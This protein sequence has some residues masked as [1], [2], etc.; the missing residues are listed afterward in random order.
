MEDLLL[1][2][3]SFEVYSSSDGARILARNRMLMNYPD[4]K[5]SFDVFLGF[6]D[7]NKDGKDDK[8]GKTKEE[9]DREKQ[10]KKPIFTEENLQKGAQLLTS[11]V[12]TGQA[13]SG[14][15][16]SFQTD[17]KKAIKQKCGRKPLLKKN[18]KNY[19][20][21]VQDYMNSL[22]GGSTGDNTGGD[23]G[24]GTSGE[25]FAEINQPKK[26]NTTTYII[27]GVVAVALIGGLIYLKKT[28]K[29]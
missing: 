26:S 28:G 9:I 2:D 23:T 17:E 18:R 25:K 3:P 10:P 6:T 19:D 24:G 11:G 5:S 8:T 20:A 27:I 13:V 16:K 12:Q 4:E 22:G 1:N 21:C 14:A 7:T 15:I 29:I